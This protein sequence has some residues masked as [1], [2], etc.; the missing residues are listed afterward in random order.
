MTPEFKRDYAYY[1]THMAQAQ[2]E[3][4]LTND[5]LGFPRV[6]LAYAKAG[7]RAQRRAMPT[8]EAMLREFRA[9]LAVRQ[10]AK[11]VGL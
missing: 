3:S 4:D 6:D 5:W 11:A 2:R 10:Y 9:D 8:S 7:E 1:T